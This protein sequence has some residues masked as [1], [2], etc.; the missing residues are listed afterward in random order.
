MRF[1]A[2]FV[3]AAVC[4]LGASAVWAVDPPTLEERADAIERVSKGPDGDRVVVGHLS[5]S[6]RIPV[7]TLRGERARTGLGWGELLIVHRLATMTKRSV[8]DVVADYRAGKGW[9]EIAR[10]GDADLARL[11]ADVKRTQ[12]VVEQRGEDQAP[13]PDQRTLPPQRGPS[14]FP[15]VPIAIPGTGARPDSGTGRTG[16]VPAHGH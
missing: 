15:Q 9:T 2:M 11:I 3:G 10:S 12:E 6:L 16:S 13:R 4:V 1:V 8:D 5:R 7:E 14:P